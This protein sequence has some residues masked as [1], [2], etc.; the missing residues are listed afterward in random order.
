MANP[1]S[2][3]LFEKERDHLVYEIAQGLEKVTANL[4]QLNRNLQDA[5]ALGQTMEQTAE[6]WR[7][8]HQHIATPLSAD[9]SGTME[10]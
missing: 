10:E 5:N 8:F 7:T 2:Q 3:A 6:V 9:D 4:A 1:T